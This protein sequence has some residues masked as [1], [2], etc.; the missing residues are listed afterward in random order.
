MSESMRLDAAVVARG[1]AGGR[2]KAKQLIAQGAVSVNGSVVKKAS[3]AVV[4]SD[5]VA[6]AVRARFVGRGGEKLQKV[7]EETA[8]SAQGAFCVDIGSSTGGFTDCMLQHGAAHVVAVDVGRDQ[9]AASLRA[10]ARV[11]SLEETDV[12]HHEAILQRIGG[13][14]ADLCTIDVSF[15]SV[16]QIWDSVQALLKPNGK[17]VCLIKPQFEAGRA[18]LSKRGVVRRSQDHIRVL[19][20]LLRFWQEAGF[21]CSY[22]SWSPICGGDGNV[23]YVALLSAASSTCAPSAETVVRGAFDILKPKKEADA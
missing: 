7:F 13:Q 4:G 20:T 17:V 19:Q 21:G 23:E 8:L 5:D 2:D 14:K 15:I 3:Y 16:T 10:D 18:A 6:C 1:L 9:L 11:T 22:L 12:R